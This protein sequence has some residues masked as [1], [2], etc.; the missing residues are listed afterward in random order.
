[1]VYERILYSSSGKS[2]NTEI[3]AINHMF[4]LVENKLKKSSKSPKMS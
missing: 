1:M 2:S 4:S 3:L